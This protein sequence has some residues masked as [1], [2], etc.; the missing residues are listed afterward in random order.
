MSKYCV[1]CVHITMHP[2]HPM[3]SEFGRC[4]FGR[5]IS[6]VTGKPTRID[7]LPYCGSERMIASRCGEEAINFAPRIPFATEEEVRD[8]LAGDPIHV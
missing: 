4:S 3:N 8:L 2:E 5:Q 1:D 6:L 7:L